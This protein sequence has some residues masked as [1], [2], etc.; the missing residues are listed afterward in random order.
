M[1]FVEKM[2][3]TDMILEDQRVLISSIRQKYQNS[4]IKFTNTQKEQVRISF[5]LYIQLS[6][7]VERALVL[8]DPTYYYLFEDYS[9]F[10]KTRIAIRDVVRTV[11]A[12]FS[13]GSIFPH[14]KEDLI[15][16][17]K[18]R[19]TKEMNIFHICEVLDDSID[20]P[21]CKLGDA[22]KTSWLNLYTVLV[23]NV[24]FKKIM[25]YL[26]MKYQEG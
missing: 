4:N 19:H 8:K 16:K 10:L 18:N 22:E 20:P 15:Q 13:C 3:N 9:P 21:I 25:E 2:V 7:M 23:N 26:T 5:K 1:K 24:S 17:K 14:Y 6:E 11:L 12:C